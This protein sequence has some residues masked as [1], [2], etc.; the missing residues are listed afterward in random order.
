[1]TL[2]PTYTF[3]DRS[4]GKFNDNMTF[5][6]EYAALISAA[7]EIDKAYDQWLSDTDSTDGIS[8]LVKLGLVSDDGYDETHNALEEREK[9]LAKILKL[10]KD[11]E[12]R[13]RM[14]GNSKDSDLEMLALRT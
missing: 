1:M 2:C 13:K 5:K 7:W 6:R 12:F 11:N 8:P 14:V 10:D 3:I 4:N 9:L